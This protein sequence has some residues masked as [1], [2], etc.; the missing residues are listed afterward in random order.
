MIKIFW[1]KIWYSNMCWLNSAKNGDAILSVHLWRC[2]P[3]WV[4]ASLRRG[5]HF[6]LSF[7]HFHPSS[8]S[9][10]LWYV[11]PDDFLPSFSWFS[12]RS[13][14]MKFAIKNSFFFGGGDSFIFH[15]Y[16]ITLSPQSSNFHSIMCHLLISFVTTVCSTESYKQLLQRLPLTCHGLVYMAPS[17][18]NIL[19]SDPV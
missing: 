4:L 6:L 15:S 10:D 5:L 12:H 19:I 17:T 9:C 3:L 8:Y 16:N 1:K 18:C 13:F 2:S 11:F 14:I 7:S